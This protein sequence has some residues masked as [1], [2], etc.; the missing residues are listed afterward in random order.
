MITFLVLYFTL[1]LIL[2]AI[3]LKLNHTFK[4]MTKSEL[5]ELWDN[6]SLA[7]MLMGGIYLILYDLYVY[8]LITVIKKG[9]A[10]LID[11]TFPEE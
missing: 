11:I 9:L 1:N 10:K 4:W 6:D 8:M 3:Y 5:L 2:T 7:F